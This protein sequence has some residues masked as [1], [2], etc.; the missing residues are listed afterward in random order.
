[1]RRARRTSLLA[2][3]FCA[4]LA[5]PVRAATVGTIRP[6]FLPDRLG[7]STAFTLALRFR[8]DQGGVPAPVSRAVVH[9]PAGLGIDL[10]G[11]SACSRA[12]L[13]TRGANG[14]PSGLRI[15]R[16][17][18]ILEVRAGSQTIPESATLAAFRGPH[19]AGK[20]TL[21]IIGQGE[22]PLYERTVVVG[23]LGAD[24]PPYGLKL[25]M[26]IPPIPTLTGEPNASLS[27]LSLTVGA[28]RNPRAHFAGAIVVPRTCPKGGFPFAADFAFEDGS[29]ASTTATTPC[30]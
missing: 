24:H 14:C 17:H 21:E 8:N 2:V 11:A 28:G 27:E 18:A 12:R 13:E 1:V 9:L 10:R 15:G 7:A 16:G 5:G 3:A 26:S 22:T 29:S 20:P 25:E 4:A 30:P 23:V 6:S 19:K